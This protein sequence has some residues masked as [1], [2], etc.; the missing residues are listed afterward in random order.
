MQAVHSTVDSAAHVCESFSSASPSGIGSAIYGSLSGPLNSIYARSST[1]DQLADEHAWMST[2]LPPRLPRKKR[3]LE[4]RLIE[5]LNVNSTFSL[6]LEAEYAEA[7]AEIQARKESVEVQKIKGLAK[8]ASRRFQM[9]ESR[10][11]KKEGTRKDV[12]HP[13]DAPEGSNLDDL[14]VVAERVHELPRKAFYETC[15]EIPN[16]EKAIQSSRS[17]PLPDWK[18]AGGVGH[19][20]RRAK[21]QPRPVIMSEASFMPTLG[22]RCYSDPEPLAPQI[23]ED[24]FE[25]QKLWDSLNQKKEAEEEEGSACEKEKPAEPLSE[26]KKGKL[27]AE[28]SQPFVDV[29][30]DDDEDIEDEDHAE[31]WVCDEDLELL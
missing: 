14:A 2:K 19:K 9:T 13:R 21:I 6:D 11:T 5:Q 15:V 17:S 20:K 16:K 23:F 8:T 24:T 1:E 3:S 22:A 31:D 7:K 29:D 28:S 27:P 12:T 4:S 10:R 18:T 30:L 25:P 26:K